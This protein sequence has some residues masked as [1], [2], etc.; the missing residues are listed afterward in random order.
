VHETYL[1]LAGASLLATQDRM[2]L[3]ALASQAM[4]QILLDHARKHFRQKRGGGGRHVPLD[5]A[6][7][8]PADLDAGARAEE[9]IS[10]DGALQRLTALDESLAQLVEW[11][12]FGGLTFEEIAELTGASSRTVKRKWSAA[13]LFLLREMAGSPPAA[14][15]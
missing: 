7:D 6:L 5:E 11:R 9:L 2:H 15:P 10:L 3:F 8:S 4:R 14:A 12:F 1:K 13:K